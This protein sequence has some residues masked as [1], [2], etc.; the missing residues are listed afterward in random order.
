[1]LIVPILFVVQNTKSLGTHENLQFIDFLSLTN[2]NNLHY[3]YIARSIM[4][5]TSCK[6]VY[7]HEKN[8]RKNVS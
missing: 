7:S 6:H 8:E 1:M 5:I 2:V 3:F 4:S